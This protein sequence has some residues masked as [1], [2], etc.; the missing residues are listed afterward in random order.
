MMAGQGHLV[1]LGDR[2]N[3]APEPQHTHSEA[4]PAKLLDRSQ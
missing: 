4:G 3:L 2:N 1:S